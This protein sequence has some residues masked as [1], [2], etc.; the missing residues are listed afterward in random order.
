MAV[1]AAEGTLLLTWTT[2]TALAA[3]L[4]RDVGLGEAALQL[5]QG[6]LSPGWLPR[7]EWWW[8]GCCDKEKKH[9]L[10]M[11]LMMFGVAQLVTTTTL[12]GRATSFRPLLPQH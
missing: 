8:L 1:V 9:Y 7:W 10:R 6:T 2:L 12:G 11:F 4:W 3:P 5:L